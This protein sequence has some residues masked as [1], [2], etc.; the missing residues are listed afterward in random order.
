[1]AAKRTVLISGCSDGS[2]GSHLAL[3]FHRNGWRVFASARNLSKMTQARASGVEVVQLDTTDDESIA[4]CVA[5]VSELTGG[6]LD[7]LVNNAGAGYSMPVLDLD[8]AQTRQLFELNVFSLIAV[9]RAFFPLLLRSP[10]GRGLVVNNTS[11]MALPHASMPFSGAYNASKAAAASFSEVLRLELA[12]FGIRVTNLVTGSVRS[13]FHANAPHVSLPPAS[14][15]NVA[16]EAVERW[17]SG[18]EATATGAD[19]VQW[20]EGVVK[21]LSRDRP[22]LWVWRGKHAMAA[23]IGSFLPVGTLDGVYKSRTGLD[24]VSRKLKEQGGLESILKRL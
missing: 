16:K 7:A 1:M 20:A 10:G 18:A 5:R 8:L 3:A 13:T 12:P 23:R 19:P 9:T 21:D 14:L 24:E 4:A 11:C 6:S 15:Y 22:P 17:M 2:L